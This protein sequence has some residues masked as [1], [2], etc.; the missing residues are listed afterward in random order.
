MK[1]MIVSVGGSPEPVIFSI[2][3]HRPDVV[4]F[5]ASQ[6]TIEKVPEIKAGLDYTPKNRK[7]LVQDENDLLGCFRDAL[8]CWD[9]L[10]AQGLGNGDVLIDFTGGTKVMS[11]ALVLLGIQKGAAFSY[12]GGSQRTKGGLGTVI[13]GSEQAFALANPWEALAIAEQQ[14]AASYFN[15]LR[16]AVAANTFELAHQKVR[17]IPGPLAALLPILKELCEGYRLWEAFD[18]H[19]ASIQLGK[20]FSQLSGYAS[21]TANRQIEELAARVQSHLDFLG[22]L[23]TQAGSSRKPCRAYVLDLVA[24]G[25]RRASEGNHDEAVLRLYRALEMQAQVQLKDHYGIDTDMVESD[26]VPDSIREEFVR[27][28]GNGSKLKLPLEASYRLLYA[29][30]DP[31]GQRFETSH[32]SFRNVQSARNRSWLAHGAN[33]VGQIQYDKLLQLT[34]SLCQVDEHE[35]PAFP[36]LQSTLERP[37]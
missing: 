37:R 14:L 4:C 8:L 10:A 25:Q 19:K 7:V 11:A 2:R 22:Q 13:T 27:R 20:A 30:D 32:N 3:S 15:Q 17:N 21:A 35:L 9:Y 31:L 5:F 28:Y 26:Q 24:N 34:L 36:V 6:Q 29:L 33:V 23:T 16:F 1:G 12:I 18:H